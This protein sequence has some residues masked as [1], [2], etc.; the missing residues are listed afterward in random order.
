MEDII[1]K[2]KRERK[3][4][5]I[6]IVITSLALAL[7]LNLFL[8]NTDS[9]K[10]IKSSVIENQVWTEKK[11]DLYIENTKNSW[12]ILLNLKSSK[13]MT[14]VKSMSFS[15]AYNK[16]NVSLKTKKLSLDNVDLINV[17]DNNWYNTVILNFKNP[18]NI[19]AWDN[20]LEIIFDKKDA[21]QKENVNLI[22]SN[23]TDSEN[24]IFSLSTSWVEF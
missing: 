12:N 1:Q 8:T 19:K 20:I 5:N 15:I 16:D 18:T 2:Y 23:M 14:K 21:T 22:N 11:A 13:E 10:Y 24:N 6:S 9:W 3:I 17:V 7:W 4:R